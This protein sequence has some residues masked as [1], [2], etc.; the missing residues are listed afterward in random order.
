MLQF[1]SSTTIQQTIRFKIQL[2][3]YT[4]KI[5]TDI[6]FSENTQEFV[7]NCM[8]KTKH[9]IQHFK[10]STI[11]LKTTITQLNSAKRLDSKQKLW[12]NYLTRQINYHSDTMVVVHLFSNYLY[13]S[14]PSKIK[15]K[16]NIFSSSSLSCLNKDLQLEWAQSKDDT[17]LDNKEKMLLDNKLYKWCVPW[18]FNWQSGSIGSHTHTY[19][20]VCCEVSILYVSGGI[21]WMAEQTSRRI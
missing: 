16:H 13:N 11:D 8:M 3:A 5:Q 12:M 2:F 14:K 18:Q 15:N 21:M 10:F 17:R 4:N 6:F 19:R 9:N 20:H 7:T 1:Y